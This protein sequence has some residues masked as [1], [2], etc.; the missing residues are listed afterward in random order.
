MNDD[1]RFHSVSYLLLHTTAVAADQSAPAPASKQT[2]Q[3][4]I[5]TARPKVSPCTPPQMPPFAPR[6]RQTTQLC[7]MLGDSRQ[8]SRG[9]DK[10]RSC[11]VVEV[12]TLQA[13]WADRF[14]DEYQEEFHS[15][16]ECGSTTADEYRRGDNESI[17]KRRMEQAQPRERVV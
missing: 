8:L 10:D 7:N 4:D 17:N 5:A 9:E 6:S 3:F 1:G 11:G 16:N 15:D 12:P 13:A 14:D 2:V